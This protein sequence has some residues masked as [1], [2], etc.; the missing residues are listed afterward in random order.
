MAAMEHGGISE[1]WGPCTECVASK[2][3]SC[4]SDPTLAVEEATARRKERQARSHLGVVPDRGR[5]GL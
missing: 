4:F 1:N 3:N 5:Y 2:F